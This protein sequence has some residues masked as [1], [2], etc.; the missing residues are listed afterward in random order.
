MLFGFSVPENVPVVEMHQAEPKKSA[1]H[2]VGE[3]VKQPL[4]PKKVPGFKKEGL[5]EP[6]ISSVLFCRFCKR[7][8][9]K[10]LW[11]KWTYLNFS[12]LE[13]RK[14]KV[15]V[16]EMGSARNKNRF[17][18]LSSWTSKRFR[19]ELPLLSNSFPVLYYIIVFMKNKVW[20]SGSADLL[21]MHL[22]HVSDSYLQ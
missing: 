12:F 21:L 22:S 5:V 3:F 4:V 17:L 2:A 7:F 18:F 6:C 8:F 14:K 11:W 16:L 10:F 9:K 19:K 1:L 13:V 20:I 15:L